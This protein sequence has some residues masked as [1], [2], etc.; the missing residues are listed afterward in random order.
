[1]DK[2]SRNTIIVSIVALAIVLITV[3]YAYFSARITGIESASTISL[4]AGRMEVVYAEGNDV[5]SFSNIYPR[6]EAWATKTFTLTGYNTTELA[7]GYKVGLNVITNGFPDD[8]LT[9]SLENIQ[10]T[11]GNPIRNVDN[12]SINGTGMVWFGPGQF[13]SGQNLIHSY[14]L[15]IYFKDNGLDQ[16]DAQ[17]AVFNAKITIDEAFPQPWDFVEDGTLLANIKSNNVV[18]TPLTN[19]GFEEA[20]TTMGSVTVTSTYVDYYWTYGTGYTDNGDGTY[21]L[22]GVNTLKFKD[23]ASNL[24]DKYIVSIDPAQTSSST[25]TLVS[26]NDLTNLIYVTSA[27]YISN[28]NRGNFGYRNLAIEPEAELSSAVDDYGTSYY[29]RGAVENNYVVFANMCWRIVRIVGDGSVKLVLYNYNPNNVTNP[30]ATSEDGDTN[31]FARYNNIYLS[32]FNTTANKNTYV[33]YMYSNN[34]NSSDFDT[35]HANDKDSTILT[36]LKGWYDEKLRSYNDMLADVIWCNDK[37]TATTSYNPFN[38]SDVTNTGIGTQ[39]T[40]YSAAQRNSQA[41]D[42]S[43][44]LICPSAGS[45]GKLSKFTARDNTNGNAKLYSNN[46]EYKIGLLTVDE[47]TFAGLIYDTTSHN[48]Q[49]YLYQNTMNHSFWTMSPAY[50]NSS[51]TASNYYYTNSYRLT[52]SVSSDSVS[53]RPSI[54]LKKETTISGGAG[55]SSNPFVVS[56]N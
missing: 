34:P 7:M 50:L 32:A 24:N 54:A 27:T 4:T 29:F 5:L 45:D 14:E 11:N 39:R 56:N 3:T 38:W 13:R 41:N 47:L 16:N 26:T 35:A 46:K 19:P 31:A 8:Y 9:Y 49:L 22:T 28:R 44:S 48:R 6:E 25:N 2:K 36:F 15:K 20:L 18:T 52:G 51:D 23:N 55:T 42:N 40:Y 21:D 30:C 17:E 37:S 43:P 53:V 10:S 12:A 1:M 33:G